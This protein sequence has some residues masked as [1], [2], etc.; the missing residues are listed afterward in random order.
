MA[1]WTIDPSHSEIGFKVRHLM[2]TN[3]KGM[4]R[5][6]ALKIETEGEDFVNPN[7]EFTA[8]TASV[9]T[10]DDKRDAHLRS[11]DFFD[12]E[13]YPEMKFISTGY[14]RKD[15][16]NYKLYGDLTIRNITQ[17]VELNVDFMG[18]MKDPFGNHKAGFIVDGTIN[19]KKWEL[20]WNAPLEAGGV[21]VS[22]DVRIQIE[23]QLIKEAVNA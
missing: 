7:I 13:K 18:I 1:K 9:D 4:F 23:V 22:E 19:R 12:S 3:V 17:P 15:K 16:E 6:Y 14:E 5:E 8:K 10:G 21:L 20:N 11:A 2:I